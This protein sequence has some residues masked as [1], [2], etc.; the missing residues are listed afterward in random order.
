[1]DN[2]VRSE[3]EILNLDEVAEEFLTRLR[4]GLNVLRSGT[5]RAAA[6]FGRGAAQLS[7][8][9]KKVI[10]KLVEENRLRLTNQII[11]PA[12]RRAIELARGSIRVA[13]QVVRGTLYI[14]HNAYYFLIDNARRF[15][16]F[17]GER[18]DRWALRVAE[19]EGR[20]YSDATGLIALNQ[21]AAFLWR[22]IR[23]STTQ[24][25]R[26][27]RTATITTRQEA[28]IKATE[29]AR[30]LGVRFRNRWRMAEFYVR[31]LLENRLIGQIRG[32]VKVIPGRIGR[33][34]S[35]KDFW[36]FRNRGDGPVSVEIKYTGRSADV[37]VG[38]RSARGRPSTRQASP[39]GDVEDWL[40]F[41]ESHKLT[42]RE[43]V[44]Q[45]RLP[46]HWMNEDWVRANG[47]AHFQ[48]R[49]NRFLVVESPGGA[50]GVKTNTLRRIR[51]SL[52][53]VIRLATPDG[54]PYL[55]RRRR[56]QN[57]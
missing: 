15:V 37:D 14:T 51:L 6:R 3:S 40:R 29:R 43:M 25:R 57:Q 12:G 26:R 30:D 13:G 9:L 1:M 50:A 39:E 19:G 42:V 33:G 11:D 2:D 32:I 46:A 24:R 8:R 21:S 47:R 34:T 41:L 54:F 53:S 36:C 10:R 23:R 4:E 49:K 27:R 52:E 16:A 48:Q 7:R 31:V 35:G 22:Q 28:W 20:L 17:L 38:E 45:R 56:R 44:R 18:L 5:A 55:P